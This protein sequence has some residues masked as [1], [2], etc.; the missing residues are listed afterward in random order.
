MLW[1]REESTMRRMTDSRATRSCRSLAQ[2][3]VCRGQQQ[4]CGP[5]GHP[6][7]GEVMGLPGRGPPDGEPIGQEQQAARK[8][9]H[10]HA[11]AG[12]HEGRV[13]HLSG[14]GHQQ[15]VERCVAVRV[16]G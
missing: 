9:G 13:A 8:V 15:V 16:I 7:L 1:M 10:G 6:R 14:H 4:H 3:A 12:Q 2:R 5:L 11:R